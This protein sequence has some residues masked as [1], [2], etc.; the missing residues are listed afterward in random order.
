MF[1]YFFEDAVFSL[2]ILFIEYFI[3]KKHTRVIKLIVIND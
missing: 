1:I 3:F 2:F